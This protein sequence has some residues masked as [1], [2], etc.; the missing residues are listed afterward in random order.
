VALLLFLLWSNSFVAVSYLLGGESAPARFDWAGLAVARFLPIAPVC[1]LY[2]L[3]WRP[4]ESLLILRRHGA[5]ALTCG[6]L[7]VPAYNFAIYYGQQHGVPAPV[8]SLT[9]ALLP[10]FVVVLAV[11]FLGER[12]TW[13]RAVAF[14]V[15]FSGL[16]LIALAREAPAGAGGYVASVAV[17]ALAP[18]SWALFSI[19]SKPVAGTVSPL[20]WTY[21]TIS[22][23]SV[24]MLALAPRRGGPELL[25]LDLP[26]WGAL[27]F[28]SVLCTLVGFAVWTWLLRQLPASTVGLTVFL[29]PP[30]TTLSKLAL[31]AAF[32]A[33]FFFTIQPLEWVGGGLALA[34][35]AIALLAAGR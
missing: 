31:A 18:L 9:T 1:I 26:G 19:L 33:T 5:R 23:G 30:L 14:A 25:T 32:P 22:L 20:T 12:L 3:G 21:L 28:L 6:L 7:A 13:R 8:A 24:P 11:V 34:G 27:L 29:N 10:L 4:R 2:C 15:S 16:A 17:T 35:L